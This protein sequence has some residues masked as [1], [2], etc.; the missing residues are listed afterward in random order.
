MKVNDVAKIVNTQTE[1]DGTLVKVVNLLPY[2]P[3]MKYSVCSIQFLEKLPEWD[4][5]YLAE[6]Q[7]LLHNLEKVYEQ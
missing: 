2:E 4:L 3:D 1:L 7:I 5:E 6:L